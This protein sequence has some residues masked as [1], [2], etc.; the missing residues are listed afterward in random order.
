MC[1]R[2]FDEQENHNRNKLIIY[3]T[4]RNDTRIM[5]TFYQNQRGVSALGGHQMGKK[6]GFIKSN[7]RHCLYY[8]CY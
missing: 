4:G 1:P 5:K 2:K 7:K 3:I 8:N 6:L